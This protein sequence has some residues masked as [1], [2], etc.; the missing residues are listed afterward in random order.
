[1][2]WRV[3]G[4]NAQ[5]LTKADFPDITGADPSHFG[6]FTDFKAAA[7]AGTLPS[8][9]FLEPSWSSTGNSQHPNYDVALG[10]AAHPRHL[11]GAAVRP[12]LG[13]DAVRAHL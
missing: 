1:M 12:R 4:Y 5:P 2:S 8:F 13:P 3:F 7:A 10:R 9:T 6:L 11:R